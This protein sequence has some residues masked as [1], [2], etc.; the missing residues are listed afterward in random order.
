MVD[1]RSQ[2]LSEQERKFISASRQLR[3]QLARD[4]RERQER[5]IQAARKLAEE[6][7]RRAELSEQRVKEQK[8]AARKLRRR[9]LAAAGAAA[10]AVIFLA[11]SLFMWRAAQEQAQLATAQRDRLLAAGLPG[12]T[13]VSA[14]SGSTATHRQRLAPAVPSY[15]LDGYYVEQRQTIWDLSPWRDVSPS[16]RN[17]KVSLAICYGYFT[18]YREKEEAVDFVHRISSTANVE[19]EVFSNRRIEKLPVEGFDKVGSLRIWE[20]RFDISNEG[21]REIRVILYAKEPSF[22]TSAFAVS[23]R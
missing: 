17:E 8:E 5:E 13:D 19:P 16:E 4:E 11:V 18:I 10:A 23:H 12:S 14:K 20:L 15:V 7:K 21:T 22:R 9:A 6:Q 1:Q 2:D 3:E